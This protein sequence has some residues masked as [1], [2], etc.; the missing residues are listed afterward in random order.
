MI[1]VLPAQLWIWFTNILILIIVSK[2]F[3]WLLSNNTYKH[4]MKLNILSL[5]NVENLVTTYFNKLLIKA[6]CPEDVIYSRMG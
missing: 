4:L 2:A 6:M 3:Q 5:V 1:Q